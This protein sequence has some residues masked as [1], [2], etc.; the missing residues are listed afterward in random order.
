MAHYYRCPP[1]Y[2]RAYNAAQHLLRSTVGGQDPQSAVALALCEVLENPGAADCVVKRLGD[3]A[4]AAPVLMG[5]L[6]WLLKRNYRYGRSKKTVMMRYLLDAIVR[7]ERPLLADE[8][9]ALQCI[10]AEAGHPERFFALGAGAQHPG[11]FAMRDASEAV[12]LWLGRYMDS[13]GASVVAQPVMTRLVVQS[14]CRSGS[15]FMLTVVLAHVARDRP[16]VIRTLKPDGSFLKILD[17]CCD[18]DPNIHAR[19][20]CVEAVVSLASTHLRPAYASSMSRFADKGL[21]GVIAE[22][23]G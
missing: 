3:A 19:R 23:L 6:R 12:R 14:L 16:T 7:M 15:E 8:V 11:V 22:V 9:T 21:A 20:R 18:P 4:N 10:A 17:E 13:R 2:D 5:I 1:G